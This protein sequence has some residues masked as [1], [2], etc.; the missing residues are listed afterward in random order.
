M[1]RLPLS[2][3]YF[4]PALNSYQRLLIHRLADLFGIKRE[5][6]PLPPVPSSPESSA[7]SSSVAELASPAQPSTPQP[8]PGTEGFTRSV[9]VLVKTEHTRKYVFSTPST[10][11]SPS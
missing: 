3:P 1:T 10:L 5:V 8:R 9:V 2:P 6:E 11:I 7:I 4:A